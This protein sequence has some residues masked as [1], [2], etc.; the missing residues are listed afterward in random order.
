MEVERPKPA[1]TKSHAN[2]MKPKQHDSHQQMEKPSNEPEIE[3]ANVESP[4]ILHGFTDKKIQRGCE[5][6]SEG[7]FSEAISVFKSVVPPTFDSLYYCGC[8]SLELGQQSAIYEAIENFSRAL[9]LPPSENKINVYYKRAFAY[10]SIGWYFEAILDY[11]EFINKNDGSVHHGYLSRGLARN[12]NGDHDN[13]LIDIQRA[14]ET[15]D[16]PYP[17]Y[18]LYCLGRAQTLAKNNSAARTTFNQL[19]QLCIEENPRS[20]ETYFYE[21]VASSE[22]NENRSTTLACFEEALNHSR[23]LKDK[24]NARFYIGLTQYK[25]GEM[26]LAIQ[27]FEEVLKLD[28]NHTK[29]NFRLGM[30]LS[31][32]DEHY[33]TA[34]DHFTKAHQSAPHRSDI[35]YERGE[36]YHKIGKIDACIRDKQ[37]A[38]QVQHTKVDPFV[39]KQYIKNLIEE[40]LANMKKSTSDV[41]K[42][43]H[44]LLSLLYG[45]VYKLTQ[46]TKIKSMSKEDY[47]T[48]IDALDQ[49]VDANSED[50]NAAFIFAIRCRL[51]DEKKHSISAKCSLDQFNYILDQHPQVEAQ[52]RQMLIGLQEQQL[53]LKTENMNILRA[54]EELNVKASEYDEAKI[55]EIISLLLAEKIEQLTGLKSYRDKVEEDEQAFTSDTNGNRKVFYRKIRVSLENKLTAMAVTSGNSENEPIIK[56]D[57]TGTK[58]AIADGL[59]FIAGVIASLVPTGG[60]VIS[61]VTGQVSSQLKDREHERYQNRMSEVIKDQDTLELLEL[62]RLVARE[63]ANRYRDQLLTIG[64]N[65]D[66]APQQSQRC[67]S[68]FPRRNK[69]KPCGNPGV[70]DLIEKV[71]SFGIGFAVRSIIGGDLGKFQRETLHMNLA[72][73]VSRAEPGFL[74]TLHMKLRWKKNEVISYVQSRDDDKVFKPK[75]LYDFYCKPG[76][77]FDENSESS[78]DRETLPWMD[79]ELYGYR[80]GTPD[81]TVQASHYTELLR[82]RLR[83]AKLLVDDDE[84]VVAMQTRH[85]NNRQHAMPFRQVYI[86]RLV[87]DFRE[88]DRKVA[89][90]QRKERE[91][92][93][94]KHAYDLQRLENILARKQREMELYNNRDITRE[95]L[96]EHLQNSTPQAQLRRIQQLEEDYKRL[97]QQYDQ[98]ITRIEQNAAATDENKHEL[99]GKIK[100]TTDRLEQYLTEFNNYKSTTKTTNDKFEA[101][102]RQFEEKQELLNRQQE[103]QTASITDL[104]Q[105]Y[106]TLTNLYHELEQM[107]NADHSNSAQQLGHVLTKISDIQTVVNQMG[108]G[109]NWSLSEIP[110]LG[111]ELQRIQGI[112]SQLESPERLHTRLNELE[113]QTSNHANLFQQFN[114]ALQQLGRQINDMGL[115][116]DLVDIEQRLQLIDRDLEQKTRQIGEANSIALDVQQQLQQ[117][118]QSL[119]NINETLADLKN[120][121]PNPSLMHNNLQTQ[122]NVPDA[123]LMAQQER[124]RNLQAEADGLRKMLDALN[125]SSIGQNETAESLK[126]LLEDTNRE[127]DRLTA[128]VSRLEQQINEANRKL[129]RLAGQIPVL[130]ENQPTPT[131]SNLLTISN[132]AKYMPY[133]E[134]LTP[135]DLLKN[136]W[137]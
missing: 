24:A 37:L 84:P 107:F 18:Y 74:K 44:F 31:E 8:V 61:C 98:L 12:D 55:K 120:N 54:I 114:D 96:A 116:H 119:A 47:K 81:S 2:S 19:K 46:D 82:N 113:I 16:E 91:E 51:H 25:C 86:E 7:N 58:S 36:L 121:V 111:Q 33:A 13:A 126:K 14:C 35:L 118:H 64:S 93:D 129:E 6:A 109:L 102:L 20:F 4:A 5:L 112:V 29:A 110:V 95:L 83:Q 30:M 62:A 70:D 73:L 27:A 59:E 68:I 63:L 48:T 134:S 131:A 42:Y 32:N 135:I 28:P 22:L 34:L 53:A 38:L 10:H 78:A 65:F 79:A 80:L 103:Q 136:I 137:K 117:L 106:D 23:T 92:N 1:S 99:D 90:H 75:L 15:I 57:R 123:D 94:M 17:K 130:P 66:Q 108:E 50:I 21:G 104:S 60:E 97:K 125:N 100:H 77:Y 85:V 89:A 11:T 133:F 88:L 101:R 105:Q 56:H 71:T 87:H 124:L 76:I 122:A 72:E 52:W 3:L 45:K 40:I 127:M 49:A 26:N 67:C 39:A 41:P 132:S 43:V 9:T 128:N 69:V 115:S